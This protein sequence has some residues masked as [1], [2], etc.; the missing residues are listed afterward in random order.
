MTDKM[1]ISE[2]FHVPSY[3]YRVFRLIAIAIL[4]NDL[5]LRFVNLEITIQ[6]PF[7]GF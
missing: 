2:I 5:S 7:A 6:N 4:H 3:D 1:I